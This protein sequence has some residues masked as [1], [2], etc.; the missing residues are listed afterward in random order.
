MS[1]TLWN[2]C[3]WANGIFINTAEEMLQG[4]VILKSAPQTRLSHLAFSASDAP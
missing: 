3:P 4:A 1:I 2:L